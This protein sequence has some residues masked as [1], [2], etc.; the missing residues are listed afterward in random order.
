MR[1]SLLIAS[2]VLLGATALPAQEFDSTTVFG[3]VYTRRMAALAEDPVLKDLG[4]TN[5]LQVDAFDV[6]QFATLDDE[7]VM[8]FA[9]LLSQT[10]DQL[11]FAECV[12]AMGGNAD[13]FM[14][15]L[16]RVSDSV[17]A[18]QWVTVLER[19]VWSSVNGDPPGPAAAAAQVRNA[20]RS[21]LYHGDAR[22]QAFITKG[23]QSD[24]LLSCE[25]TPWLLRL[26]A[27]KKPERIA[28]LLRGIF[29]SR[30]SD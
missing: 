2:F 15:T 26:L 30:S 23:S 12:A 14:D 19:V 8:L 17:A 6:S 3:R 5:S 27:A 4:G 22:R 28:P 20:F 9:R 10:L 1:R 21:I 24:A 25:V 13:G 7:T 16:L 11:N 18:E 29:A